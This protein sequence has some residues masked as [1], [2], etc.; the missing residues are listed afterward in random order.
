VVIAGPAPVVE[1]FVGT[2]PQ[3]RRED[4][5]SFSRI[6]LDGALDAGERAEADAAGLSIE[7]VSLQQLMVSTTGRPHE[8]TT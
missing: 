5:G 4:V 8:E 3:L 2:R 7:A 6:T 1:R